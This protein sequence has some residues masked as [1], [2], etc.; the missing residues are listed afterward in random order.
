MHVRSIPCSLGMY[1]ENLRYARMIHPVWDFC[2]RKVLV[3]NPRKLQGGMALPNFKYYYWE[4]NI[5]CML[6]WLRYHLNLNC[7]S[8]VLM[9]SSA[10]KQTSLSA[11]LGA[12]LP[13]I[14]RTPTNNPV[15]DHSLRVWVQFRRTF[16]FQKIYLLSPIVLNHLFAPSIQDNTIMTWHELGLHCFQDLFIEKTL[17]L[18]SSCQESMTCQIHISHFFRFLQVRNPTSHLCPL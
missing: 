18:L 6:C 15:V 1:K 5:Q 14:G 7:P 11:Y 8:W 4:A 13:G 10:C 17:P 12:A 2:V 3:R 16:G 9:E